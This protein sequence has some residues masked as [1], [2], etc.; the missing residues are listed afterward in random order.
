MITRQVFSKIAAIC[1]VLFVVTGCGP[2][3]TDGDTDSVGLMKIEVP[4]SA[5][6]VVG[7]IDPYRVNFFI[8]NNE[9]RGYLAQYKLTPELSK[10]KYVSEYE[11]PAECISSYRAKGNLEHWTAGGNIK[12]RDTDQEVY[13]F[14]SVNP[15]CEPGKALV[16]WRLD[17]KQ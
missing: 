7:L 12:W 5:T 13:R 1:A 10:L 14:V 2:G 17:M 11:A 6:N 9:W 16:R 4:K 15:D 8:P 3:W